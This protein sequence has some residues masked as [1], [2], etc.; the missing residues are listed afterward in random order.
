MTFAPPFNSQSKMADCRCA[1]IIIQS[2]LKLIGES[3]L[4][5]GFDNQDV[6]SRNKVGRYTGKK[7]IHVEQGY[8]NNGEILTAL[9]RVY[10]HSTQLLVLFWKKKN[11]YSF[12]WAKTSTMHLSM[13]AKCFGL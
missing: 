10:K 3:L 11:S 6:L 12:T 1:S 7:R 9:C 13:R 2:V 4:T 8:S 5:C